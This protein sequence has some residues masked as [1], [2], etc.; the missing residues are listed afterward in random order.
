MDA[1]R[2]SR[3]TAPASVAM[4]LTAFSGVQTITLAESACKPHAA[5]PVGRER[6]QNCYLG[7]A[8]WVD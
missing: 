5:L 3:S 4:A 8:L 6:L 2:S 1:P 7:N